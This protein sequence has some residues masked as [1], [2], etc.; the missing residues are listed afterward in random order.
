MIRPRKTAAD[1]EQRPSHQQNG[2]EFFG[3]PVLSEMAARNLQREISPKENAGDGAG[4]LG[5]EMQVVTNVRESKGD[6]GA[7]DEGDGVH[8]ER[9]RDDAGPARRSD[10]W[11]AV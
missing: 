8:D 7:V 10:G 11:G 9:D 2:D 5:I 4:L 1:G 6:I 3:A